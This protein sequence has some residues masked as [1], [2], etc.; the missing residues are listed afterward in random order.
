MFKKLKIKS[1]WIAAIAAGLAMAACSGGHDGYSRKNGVLYKLIVIGDFT[2][3][4]F[5]V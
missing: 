3:R 4:R 2:Y 1:V 5:R